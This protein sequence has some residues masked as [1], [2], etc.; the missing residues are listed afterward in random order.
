LTSKKIGTVS[1]K[2]RG[3]TLFDGPSASAARAEDR[4]IRDEEKKHS[5]KLDG[6]E[7]GSRT[8]EWNSSL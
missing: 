8:R 5:R 3:G 1:S 4:K 6:L 7:G 2:P